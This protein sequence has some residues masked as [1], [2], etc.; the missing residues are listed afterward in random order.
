MQLF[1][2]FSPE[3]RSLSKKIPILSCY[4]RRPPKKNKPR[5]AKIPEFCALAT[6]KESYMNTSIYVAATGQHIGKTT[7]TLGIMA[8]LKAY[9]VQ[10]VGYC[11]PVGQKVS[12]LA[13][14]QVDKDAFLFSK[15]MDF[16]LTSE[17]HSPVILGKGATAAYLDDPAAFDY[18][19]RIA[20][21]SATLRENNDVVV[22]EGTG[23]PGVGSIVNLSNAA[24]AKMVG[25]KVVIVVEGG[26]GNTIDKL[27]LSLAKFQEQEVPVIGVIVNKVWPEKLEK[28]KYYVQKKLDEMGVNLLGAVPFDRSL[29]YPI[30]RTINNAVGGHFVQ[31]EENF[32]NRVED[33]VPGSLIEEVHDIGQ[34][35]NLLLLVSH[36]RAREAIRKLEGITKRAKMT[37]SPL[38]GILLTGEHQQERSRWG[39]SIYEYYINKYRLPVVS[40]ELDTLGAFTKINSLEVKINTSTPWKVERAI[41][42]IKEHVDLE[43]I[44][45]KKV[46]EGF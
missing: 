25:A 35:R 44:A 10:K 36:K 17:L 34:K 19:E 9:G 42:L 31:F 14:L 22:Y 6:L 20:R 27:S 37:E 26:I 15:I 12:T 1:R 21:A 18:K 16:E 29:S 39:S 30:M 41:E 28:I 24:V 8:A 13:K 33:I 4:S 7:T 5:F 3:K 11:K 38:S 2:W 45:G 40:T 32:A 23:H 46:Y 43:L